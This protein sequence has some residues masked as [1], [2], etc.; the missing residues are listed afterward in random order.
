MGE[1]VRQRRDRLAQITADLWDQ[2]TD[3]H[4]DTD[5]EAVHAALAHRLREEPSLVADEVAALALEEIIRDLMAP[6]A[7]SPLALDYIAARLAAW[8]SGDQTLASV[9]ARLSYDPARSP[10]YTPDAYLP[11]IDGTF[12]QMRQATRDDVLRWYGYEWTRARAP[13]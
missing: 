9:E 7:G 2:F 8:R 13:R 4:G 10:L 11:L 6:V 1:T 12:V 3:E 5:Q